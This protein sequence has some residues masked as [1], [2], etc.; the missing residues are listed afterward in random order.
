V[1]DHNSG[2]PEESTAIASSEEEWLFPQD[3]N[4]GAGR[5][6]YAASQEA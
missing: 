6:D 2:S 4:E 1:A 5:T 3:A